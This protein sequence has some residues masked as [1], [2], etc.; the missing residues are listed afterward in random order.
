[1]YKISS[2]IN[3]GTCLE[4]KCFSLHQLEGEHQSAGEGGIQMLRKTSL[5][6]ELYCEVR[7]SVR[8]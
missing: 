6:A 7:G 3:L 1:M 5:D 8:G 4:G 2:L